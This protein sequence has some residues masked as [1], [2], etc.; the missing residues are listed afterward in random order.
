MEAIKNIE[1]AVATNNFDLR[2]LKKTIERVECQT[3]EV[4]LLKVKKE[5]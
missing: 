1:D 5:M 3:R 2:K 4:Q